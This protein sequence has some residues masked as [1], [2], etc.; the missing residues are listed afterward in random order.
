[1]LILNYNINFSG[2]KQKNS[3]FY[4]LLFSYYLLFILTKC[5]F[6]YLTKTKINT[7]NFS[8]KHITVPRGPFVHKKSNKRFVRLVRQVQLSYFTFLQAPFNLYFNKTS[9]T[10]LFNK[11]VLG[12]Y[13]KRLRVKLILNFDQGFLVRQVNFP[14]FS[15]YV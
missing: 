8:K 13:L 1:M 7:F 11:L 10:L 14:I 4:K 2:L 6:A 5:S 15:V 3:N 9:S 12:S